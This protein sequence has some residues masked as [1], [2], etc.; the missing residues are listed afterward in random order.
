VQERAQ[1]IHN[2]SQQRQ[3]RQQP[4]QP[5]EHRGS[6][7]VVSLLLLLHEELCHKEG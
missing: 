3:Q 5:K 7:R 1:A 6:W 4:H 2:P